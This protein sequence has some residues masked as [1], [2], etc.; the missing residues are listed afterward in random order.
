MSHALKYQ[1]LDSINNLL[2]ERVVLAE[3]QLSM[4][5]KSYTNLLNLS[6]QKYQKQKEITSDFVRLSEGWKK[7]AEY[8][9]KKYRK[10]RRGKRI[11]TYIGLTAIGWAAVK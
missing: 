10:S 5:Y 4:Q 8:Y 6:E 2:S 11:I 9:Q 7:E 1:I 3:S